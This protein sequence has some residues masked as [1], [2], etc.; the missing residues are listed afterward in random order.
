MVLVEDVTIRDS[1]DKKRHKMCRP[2]VPLGT[3][4]CQE[5][6]PADFKKFEAE[7]ETTVC[8]M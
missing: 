4:T 3:S 5:L 1:L 2:R 6:R 7:C 8:S